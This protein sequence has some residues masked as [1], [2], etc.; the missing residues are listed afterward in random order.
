M[1][2]VTSSLY[3][4]LGRLVDLAASE[5][6]RERQGD[7][8]V[9]FTG[10]LSVLTHHLGLLLA[11][12]GP[13]ALRGVTPF[14]AGYGSRVTVN[15]LDSGVEATYVLMSGSAM[16]LEAGHVSIDSPL[17]RSL[18][19]RAEGALVEV[20]TPR[21]SARLR[22]VGVKTLFEFIEEVE[23]C[24]GARPRPQLGVGAGD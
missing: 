7:P 14:A 20:V 24:L 1:S 10:S 15:D 19:G 2:F 21:G 22:V 5:A 16:D 23:A 17:G 12:A 18:S 9:P 4:R 13:D 3:E 11:G 8:A 6:Y